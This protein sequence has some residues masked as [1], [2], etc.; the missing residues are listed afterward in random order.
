[1]AQPRGGEGTRRRFPLT[2]SWHGIEVVDWDLPDCVEMMR[3][4]IQANPKLWN[5]D[6]GES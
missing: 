5:E 4:F 6:I 2:A 1:M 3:E